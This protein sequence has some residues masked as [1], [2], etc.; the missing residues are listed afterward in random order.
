VLLDRDAELATLTEQI[1]LVRNRFGRVV[2]VEGPAGIGKSS[3]LAAAAGMAE[4][5]GG[6]VLRAHGGPLEQDAAWGIA[7]EL[8]E[9]LRRGRLWDELTVGAAALARRVLDP[10]EGEPASGGDAMHA[11]A[12]GLAWLAT[13]L[14]QRSPTMLII[15][16]VHWADAPSLRWLAQQ[17]RSLDGLALGVL[18]AVRSGEPAGEPGLLAELLAASPEPTLRPRALGP[19][20]AEALVRERLPTAVASFAHACHAVTAGNPFL[21]TALLRQLVADEIEP[22]EDVASRLSAFGPEQVARSVMRQLSRLPEGA[23]ELIRAVAVLGPGAPL[24]RAARLARLEQTQAPRVADSLRAAGLLDD[25]DQLALA[26][27]LVEGALQTSLPRGERAIWH[28]DAASLLAHEGADPEQIALHLLRTEPSE[29]PGT[30][31][32]LCDA[33]DR[34]SARGAPQS[35]SAFLRRALAEPPRDRR[36][37]ADIRLRL[38]LA[39]SAYLAPDATAALHA[40]VE[41]AESPGQRA[42]IALRGAR[43][44]G[45]AGHTR[46]AFELCREAL[47]DPGDASP[48][49]IA[50]LEAE[51]V[52][53]AWLNVDTHPEARRRLRR[54]AIR[55][56]PLGLWRV[57]AA[58]E[59]MLDG[60]PSHETMGLLRPVLELDLLAGETDSLVRTFTTLVVLIGCDELDLARARCDAIIDTARPRGWLV[61]L[62]QGSQLRA[63]ACIRAGLVRDAEADARLAFEYKLPVTPKGIMLPAH[64][65]IDALVELD[66]L[67]GAEAVLAA[68]DLD[69][70]PAGT[71][72]A[73]LFRQSR[74]RLRLAQHRPEDALHDLLAAAEHWRQLSVQH[75]V[76]A[77]WRGEATEALTRLGDHPTA[78][79]L[80]TEQLGLAERLGTPAARGI[81][82]R[83]LARTAPASERVGLLEHA[84][85]ILADSQ[86][87]LEH[88][89]AL[90]ELGSALRRANRRADARKPL[91]RALDLTSRWGM[92]LLAARAT[93]ELKAAGARPRRDLV[94]GPGALTAAEH[95]VATLAAAGHNNREIAER[96][97]VTQRTVETHLT[98]AFQKLSITS[99]TELAARMKPPG[100]ADHVPARKPALTV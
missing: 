53:N 81:A 8:F 61:A 43:A 100:R 62:A 13:N 35:A 15:D 1:E 37:E 90:V 69:E 47:A 87:Q 91:R 72:G 80:A 9:P 86:A 82:L 34:A 98:H 58:M 70:P 85:K 30:V 6:V 89:R 31:A 60:R 97:Y 25:G 51:L 54:P 38:G 12:R 33:A 28:A 29:E 66:D 21:L 14:A 68:V 40:A 20:A 76:L 44:L 74:A 18:V 4:A 49:A 71:V 32:T 57:N 94:S 78:A 39:L 84:V 73:P 99:R 46:D 63:R 3:L 17:A 36:T 45:L 52:T 56:S 23:G 83:A 95:R 5:D 77:G 22:N 10:D 24:R 48:E 88:A 2:T 93:D 59:S 27:P 67:D 41:R 96:L 65:L 7:R 92:R 16:D 26:H 11:A 75:P 55:P 79:R 42:E 50:R 64:I 19:A